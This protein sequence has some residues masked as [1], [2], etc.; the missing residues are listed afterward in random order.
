MVYVVYGAKIRWT[1]QA[2]LANPL[3]ISNVPFIQFLFVS[4]TFNF[5][6]VT[7]KGQWQ[8]GFRTYKTCFCSFPCQPICSFISLNAAVPWAPILEKCYENAIIACRLSTFHVMKS[9]PCYRNWYSGNV[10]CYDRICVSAFLH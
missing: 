8:K 7:L 9:Y 1:I 5:G 6:F 10:L 3:P 4:P 2:L